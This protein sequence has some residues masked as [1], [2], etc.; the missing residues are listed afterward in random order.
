MLVSVHS[1]RYADVPGVSSVLFAPGTRILFMHEV[2]IR[3]GRT[4]SVLD[5]TYSFYGK[6]H[7]I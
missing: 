1:V 3:P 6:F 7:L 4:L 2:H 5:L